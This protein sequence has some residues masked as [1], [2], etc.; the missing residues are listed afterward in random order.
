MFGFRRQL[1]F[2][3]LVVLGAGCLRPGLLAAQEGGAP[4]PTSPPRVVERKNPPEP[5]AATRAALAEQNRKAIKKDVER[6]FE[7][8]TQLKTEVE[9]TDS[10]TFLSLPVMKKAEE[11]EKLAKHVKGS[12]KSLMP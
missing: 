4:P 12:A 1:L 11:I 10:A 3:A 8:A 2:S 5:D 9:Q 7:L 6:L